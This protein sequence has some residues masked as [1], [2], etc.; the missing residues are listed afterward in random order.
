MYIWMQNCIEYFL[1][2]YELAQLSLHQCTD[3]KI[4]DWIKNF[5]QVILWIIFSEQTTK[6]IFLLLDEVP[7]NSDPGFECVFHGKPSGDW[8]GIKTNGVNLMMGL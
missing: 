4:D 8:K 5:S 6:D 2:H 1:P 7:C 3:C